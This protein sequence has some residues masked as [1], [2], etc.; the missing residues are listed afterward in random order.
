M[1]S[2]PGPVVV[3]GYCNWLVI[4][5]HAKLA[6]SHHYLFMVEETNPYHVQD[7]VFSKEHGMCVQFMNCYA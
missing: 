2:V 6:L 7:C 4:F 5:G 3:L 1:A